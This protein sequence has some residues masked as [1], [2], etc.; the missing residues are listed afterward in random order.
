[1]RKTLCGFLIAAALVIGVKEAAAQAP[2]TITVLGVGKVA[3]DVPLPLAGTL[4]QTYR[5]YVPATALVPIVVPP[6]CI[7]TGASGTASSCTFPLT[8]LNLTI[9]VTSSLAMTAV[10]VGVDGELESARTVA[11]FVLRRGGPP[12]APAFSSTPILP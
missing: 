2:P 9:G 11:P 12:A 1:M 7:A 3:F 8:T 10:I 4:A 6:T 5:A